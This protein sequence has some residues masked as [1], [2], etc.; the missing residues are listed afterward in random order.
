MAAEANAHR[1][2]DRGGNKK[3]RAASNVRRQW[4]DDG[5]AWAGIGAEARHKEML[6]I[7]WD[8]SIMR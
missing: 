5:E 2:A 7:N 4:A 6:S 3:F 1:R 8:G